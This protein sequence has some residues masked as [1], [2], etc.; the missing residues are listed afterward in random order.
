MIARA[1]RPVEQKGT[2]SSLS[3]ILYLKYFNH[4]ILEEI[5]LGINIV[6]QVLE[7]MLVLMNN[8]LTVLKT[9]WWGHH[10]FVL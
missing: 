2:G 4:N 10:T 6:L 1:R 7:D 9:N 3:L 8:V 5:T